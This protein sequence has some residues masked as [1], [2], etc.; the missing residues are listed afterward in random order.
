MC[1]REDNLI[2][3]I[4]E[5]VELKVCSKCSKHGIVKQNNNSFKKSFKKQ[6]TNKNEA[7]PLKL[8]SNF[9][10]KIREARQQSN[11]SQEDFALKLKHKESEVAKWENGSLKPSIETAKVLQRILRIKLVEEDVD[12]EV[13]YKKLSNNEE[14]TIA[15]FIKIKKRK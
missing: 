5:G 4:V 9:A 15:D 8:I 13:D 1:G 14:V 11:L 3:S 6:F 2:L 10:Q 12:P 7:V